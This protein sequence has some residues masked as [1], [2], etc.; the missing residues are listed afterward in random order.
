L[1]VADK[2]TERNSLSIILQQNEQLCYTRYMKRV[3]RAT[4]RLFGPHQADRI[5]DGCFAKQQKIQ[6]Y[7]GIY[8]VIQ[9]DCRG[10]NNLSYTINLR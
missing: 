4:M 2:N 3:Q 9:N 6:R 10:V 5:K 1:N 7:E 8:R